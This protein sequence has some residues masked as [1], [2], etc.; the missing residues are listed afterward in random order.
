MSGESAFAVPYGVMSAAQM[1]AMKVRRYMDDHAVGPGALRAIAM[2]SYHHAQQ[3]P[4]A[5]MYGRPLTEAAYDESRWI[6]EPF[7]L[8]DCCLENDG[9]AACILVSADRASDQPH[10][11]CYLLAA[12]SGAGYRAGAPAHNAPDYASAHFQQVAARPFAMAGVHPADVGV[13]QAYENF[14]GGVLMA[15][16]EA[17]FCSPRPAPR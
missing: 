2:A 6:I 17:G 8:Y 7:R 14:A 5:I 9:A 11:P 3:N 13:V 10:P 16:V 15:L 12:T 4:K 1:F